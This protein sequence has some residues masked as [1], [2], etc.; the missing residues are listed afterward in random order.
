MQTVH[1]DPLLAAARVII[2]MIQ[3]IAIFGIVMLGIGIGA[4]LSVQNA[5]IAAKLAEAGAPASGLWLLIGAMAMI[6]VLLA[7]AWRFFQELT[8]MVNTVSQG[9]PFQRENA[10]RL[11]RMGWLS[12][13]AQ[14]LIL[15]LA[16]ITAWFEPYFEKAGHNLDIGFDVDLTG[17]LMTLVLFILARV[18]T[19]GADMREE[20]EGTV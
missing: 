5:A 3:I 4:M 7:M 11:T 17:I 15:V 10:A 9:D 16:M 19:R 13:A 8:G 20:L 12:L 18:F 14:G 6:M 1:K 2:V